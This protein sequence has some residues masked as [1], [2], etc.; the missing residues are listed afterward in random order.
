MRV[1]CFTP[2]VELSSIGL[3]SLGLLLFGFCR[4]TRKSSCR[5]QALTGL[6]R[7]SK[8][9]TCKEEAGWALLGEKRDQLWA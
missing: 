5:R 9:V 6:S 2:S 7:L 3:L 1:V 4:I 8:T